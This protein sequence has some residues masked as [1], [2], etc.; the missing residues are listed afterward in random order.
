M[1]YKLKPMFGVIGDAT[2]MF[3]TK[4]LLCSS[5]ICLCLIEN[6]FLKFKNTTNSLTYEVQCHFNYEQLFMKYHLK[7]MFGVIGDATTLVFPIK[8][9]LC[10]PSICFCLMGNHCLQFKK[11]THS[12]T[13]EVQWH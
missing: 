11:T 10:S 3:P 12:L 4:L 6:H 7:S 8:L 2:F 1:K 5:S 9:L 13:Y